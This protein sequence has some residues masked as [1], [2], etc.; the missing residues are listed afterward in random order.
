MENNN[1]LDQ[2]K[3]IYLPSQISSWWPLAYGWWIV[4]AV[5]VLLVLLCLLVL[6]IRKKHRKYID[7]VVNDFKSNLGETYVTK[8]KEVVQSI[9]VYLKRIAIYKFTKDDIKLLHGEA[10]V[11]YLNSKTKV[12]VFEGKVAEYLEN[13]YKPQ[14]LSDIE[15]EKIVSA[16][17][18]WVRSVL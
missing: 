11:K 2:L 15:L 7:N 9:S 8:P 18:K 5:L 17:E 13:T 16:S 14:E 1:L 3:D 12:E 10:W 4:I 6:R